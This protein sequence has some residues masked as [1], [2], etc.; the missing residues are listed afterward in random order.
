MNLFI[1]GNFI[2]NINT[3]TLSSGVGIQ[4]ITA[5]RELCEGLLGCAVSDYFYM[6]LLKT[7][8]VNNYGVFVLDNNLL[9]P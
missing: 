2:L 1:D 8:S 7:R 6:V 9:V 3:W 4:Q 5:M